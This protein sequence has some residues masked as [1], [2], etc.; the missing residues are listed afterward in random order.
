VTEISSLYDGVN[1]Q[2]VAA[3]SHLTLERDP[4]PKML[5]SLCNDRR[6]TKPRNPAILTVIYH[7]QNPSKLFFNSHTKIQGV[8]SSAVEDSD[9][10]VRDVLLA[11]WFLTLQR[12]VVALAILQHVFLALYLVNYTQGQPHLLL[13][14]YQFFPCKCNCNSV[15]AHWIVWVFD[16]T[17]KWITNSNIQI[18]TLAIS[19]YIHR[20]S[21]YNSIICTN[22]CTKTVFSLFSLL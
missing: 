3:F 18:N 7:H 16:T 10:V 13:H 5:E 9:L 20:A 14:F 21:F 22:K 4:C 6:N 8:C 11:T 2:S 17:V 1:W 12:I 15:T 19:L